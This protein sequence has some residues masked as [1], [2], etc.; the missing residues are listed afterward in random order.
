MGIPERAGHPGS[1]WPAAVTARSRAGISKSQNCHRTR[2]WLGRRAVGATP[3][4]SAKG[5]GN[6]NFP[7]VGAPSCVSPG[8]M[9]V[10]QVARNIPRWGLPPGLSA[11]RGAAPQSPARRRRGSTA[12]H[13][14]LSRRRPPRDGKPHCE[15]LAGMRSATAQRVEG[16][17]SHNDAVIRARVSRCN[18]RTRSGPARPKHR[19]A[20]AQ[21]FGHARWVSGTA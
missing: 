3:V 4:G 15:P 11:S 8:P 9:A 13:I 18:E 19:S 2:G 14:P 1:G 10:S 20:L 17:R 5:Y 21:S 12:A 7:E 16:Y 6:R